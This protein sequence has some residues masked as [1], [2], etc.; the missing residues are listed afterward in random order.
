VAPLDSGSPKREVNR[1][2]A[3]YLVFV[4]LQLIGDIVSERIQSLSEKEFVLG[5][6]M[7]IGPRMSEETVSPIYTSS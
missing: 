5:G 1:P 2:T 7:V 3:D 6:P 4:L